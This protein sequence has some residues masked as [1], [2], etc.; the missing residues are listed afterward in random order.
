MR[1]NGFDPVE[2]VVVFRL[3]K[4]DFKILILFLQDREYIHMYNVLK[5]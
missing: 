1:K 2:F 3:K 5:T 4:K